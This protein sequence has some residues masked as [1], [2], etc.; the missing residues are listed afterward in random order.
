ME[1]AI[2]SAQHQQ[3]VDMQGH[4]GGLRLWRA[5]PGTIV[6][7]HT[8]THDPSAEERWEYRAL[9]SDKTRFPCEC[10]CVRVFTVP[11]T[12]RLMCVSRIVISIGS[13]CDVES[14]S[15]KMARFLSD[16]MRKSVL[17]AC[18]WHCR[19]PLCSA[20]GERAAALGPLSSRRRTSGSSCLP[21][22]SCSE[23]EPE[24]H[25]LKFTPKTGCN[26]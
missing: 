23:V 1:G 25:T 22:G 14:S 18:S 24:T 6:L 17:K 12:F 5:V 2:I 15:R 26:Q 3:I 9:C 4:G 11:R 19:K 7:H 21:Q 20:S 16:V 8:G 10:V 13:T